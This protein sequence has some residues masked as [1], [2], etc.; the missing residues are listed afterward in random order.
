MD[1]ILLS[2]H[3]VAAIFGDP[4]QIFAYMHKSITAGSYT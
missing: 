4:I 2:I 1:H 3:H